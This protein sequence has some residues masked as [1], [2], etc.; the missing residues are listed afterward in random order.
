MSSGYPRIV[1]GELKRPGSCFFSHAEADSSPNGFIDTGKDYRNGRYEERYYI[2]LQWLAGALHEA[3]WLSPE[4]SSALQADRDALSAEVTTLREAE[5]R[6]AGVVELVHKIAPPV[7][8]T[9]E[10]VNTEVREPTH[11]EVVDYIRTHPEF[12]DYLTPKTATEIWF[13]QNRN[14]TT[15]RTVVPEGVDPNA[16]AFVTKAEEGVGGVDDVEDTKPG[17]TPTSVEILGQE[18]DLADILSFDVADVLT[19]SEGKPTD[20]L[21][22]LR[23]AEKA[24]NGRV[25]LLRGLSKIIAQAPADGAETD[26]E[27]L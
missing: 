22:A 19:W 23:D 7:P 1:K 3:G 13:E 25:T 14:Q 9:V 4:E 16:P 24:G 15:E 11:A 2:S 6:W 21:V 20:A 12:A 17:E 5:A 10:V 18:F 26:N 27:A 8:K